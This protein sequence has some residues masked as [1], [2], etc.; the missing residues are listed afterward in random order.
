[1]QENLQHPDTQRYA[2]CIEGS[3]RVDGIL[4]MQAKADAA[5]SSPACRT[6]AL[7]ASLAR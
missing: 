3:K 1:M 2:R 7:L 5:Y 6:S 4:Q